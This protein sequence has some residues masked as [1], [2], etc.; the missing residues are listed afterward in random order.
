MSEKRPRPSSDRERQPR[1]RRRTTHTLR[2]VQ[3]RP[4]YVEPA[5]QDPVFAQAQLLRSI[6]AALHA[7]GFDSVKPTALEMFRSH[8]EE[9]MLRFATYIRTS[10]QAERRTRPVAQDFA[11]ALSLT[12]DTATASL[13]QPHL[14]LP[15]PECISY[16]SIPEPAPPE[17][18][19]PDFTAL[20]QPLT[21]TPLPRYVP[22]HF[23][24][25]PSKHAWVHTPVYAE[26]EKDARK[27]RE[28]ATQEGLLAEQALRKLATAA[29]AGVLKAEKRRSSVLSGP[30]KVVNGTAAPRRVEDRSDTFA[31][32]MKE[33]GGEE[34]EEEEE[35]G[36]LGQ[37]AAK[38]DL[39]DGIDERAQE[40]V[41]VNYDMG[42]W[43]H[44]VGGRAA[45]V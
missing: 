3:Q 17:A 24:A 40:G 45:R 7:V 31:D 9:Y 8:T 33:V 6:G 19:I 41:V 22:P 28:K 25:L 35:D 18:P 26:R 1:K 10:M 11:M 34:E 23:P 20:L 39:E 21:M 36:V 5:S 14:Q 30:G 29:K 38:D 12:P 44:S 4:H 42:Y 15:I 13:L 37:G 43:R 16:P 27:M 2:R 32:V